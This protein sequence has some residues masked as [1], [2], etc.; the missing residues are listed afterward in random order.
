[1]TFFSLDIEGAE[2]MALQSIDFTKVGFGIILVEAQVRHNQDLKHLA[3]RSF[4]ENRGYVFMEEY[5]GSCW[6]YNSRFGEIY[7]HLLINDE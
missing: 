2:F 6:F 4:L 1:L 7:S 3:L 5:N